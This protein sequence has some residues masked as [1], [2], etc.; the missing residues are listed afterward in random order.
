M[1]H[2]IAYLILITS[3]GCCSSEFM[4]GENLTLPKKEYK[5]TELRIDGYYYCEYIGF[6][7][8]D[9]YVRTYFFYENG[10][11][12]YGG[13]TKKTELANLEAQFMTMEWQMSN[14]KYKHRWGLFNIDGDKII[15]ERW[16]PNSPGQPK[17]YVN[18]G[19]IVNETT[20]HITA[21][22]RPD[23]SERI[24]QDETYHFKQFSP[25]PD[26]T[27]VFIK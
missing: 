19:K 17:V 7:S 12:Q 24:E 27:N 2:L 5:G 3:C 16:Y 13:A 14:R 23:G 10:I 15:F 18:E 20:F 8:N 1:K 25:K 21:F 4:S 11:V 9:I 22:Y 26:S 6:G